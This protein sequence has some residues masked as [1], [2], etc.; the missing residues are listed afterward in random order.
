M[1][2]LRPGLLVRIALFVPL[3]L[4]TGCSTASYLVQ[5]GIGQLALYNH[6][7]PLQEVIA[8]PHTTEKVRERLRWVPEIKKMVE[9]ELG[10]PPTSNY[11]T[12]VQLDRKYL[13]WALTAAE[14]FELKTVKWSFPFFG[15]FPYLGFFKEKTAQDWARDYQQ[16]GYDTYVRGASAYSTLG[17]LRDPMVSSMLYRDKG[18]MVDLIFHESTHGQIYIKGQ[19][20]FNEQIANYVGDT[21]EKQWL[22]RTYGVK[23]KERKGWDNDRSDRRRFGLMLRKFAD[24]LKIY[25]PASSNLSVQER[26]AGKMSRFNAFRK[27]LEAEPWAGTGWGRVGA[28]ITNNAGLLAFLTYEDEQSLFDELDEKCGGHLK[29][30]LRYLKSFEREWDRLSSDERNTT[31]PQ[32]ILKE[33]LRRNAG[34]AVCLYLDA[35]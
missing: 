2:F 29:D 24:E 27:A 19:V 3:L 16:K 32:T 31:K 7:R 9:T 4:S 14:P 34:S 1:G 30:A 18:A 12:Y 13:T 6:E 8:D 22:E 25:Y 23:S 10:V 11:T 21:A 28:L 26:Q 17:W 20:D 15:A 35:K 33:R 5:A